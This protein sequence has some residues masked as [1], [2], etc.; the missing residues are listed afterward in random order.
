MSRADL[1][2]FSDAYIVMKG[3]IAATTPDNAKRD[4]SVAFENNAPFIKY[5]SKINNVLIEN[6]EDLDAV[7]PMYNLLEY[8]KNYR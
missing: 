1:C 2:D 4:K 6:V 8:S 5:V 7:M 3:T